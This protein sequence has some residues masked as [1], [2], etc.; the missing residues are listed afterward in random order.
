MGSAWL[1]SRPTSCRFE[2]ASGPAPVSGLAGA[3]ALGALMTFPVSGMPANVRIEQAAAFYSGFR[4]RF[5]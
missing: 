2:A 4:A 3:V 5:L 1:A